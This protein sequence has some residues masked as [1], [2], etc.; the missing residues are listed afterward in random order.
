MRTVKRIFDPGSGMTRG[1]IVDA[2]PMTETLRDG[3]ALP[4]APPLKTALRF[5]VVGGMRGAADRCMNIGLCR[6][7]TSGVMCPSYIATNNEEHS[8]RGRA[9]ALVK[10]LSE[11]DPHA[12]LGGERLHEVLDLCLMCKAC[13]SECPMSVDMA[14]LKAETLAHHHEI[15][16]VPLRSRIFGSIRLLNRIGSA[17]APL[18]NLPRRA[19]FVRR[20]MDRAL[21]ITAAR[22]LP[23]FQRDSL[24][25]W[26]PPPPP[27]PAPGPAPLG[28]PQLSPPPFP[29]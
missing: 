19:A 27:G 1:K 16:G 2:P 25:R 28:P 6:K 29:T 5:E 23:V 14:S 17:T 9:N 24:L 18:S 22:P 8:T 13:K 4:P 26:F 15:H 3:D 11:P 21:G 10:A 20:I 7:S 12:A